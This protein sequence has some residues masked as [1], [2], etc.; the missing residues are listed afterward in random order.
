M[1]PPPLAKLYGWCI[2]N[3]LGYGVRSLIIAG[4]LRE[5]TG[6]GVVRYHALVLEIGAE[7]RLVCRRTACSLALSSAFFHYRFC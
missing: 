3:G 2:G 5:L 4:F 1:K 6:S 7:R